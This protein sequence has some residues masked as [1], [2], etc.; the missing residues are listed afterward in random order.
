MDREKLNKIVDQGDL[1]YACVFKIGV[2]GMHTDYMFN[3]KGETIASVIAKFAYEADKIII[4][5]ICDQFVCESL[6][7]GILSN[8]PDQE[9]CCDIVKHLLSYQMGEQDS[10][11]LLIATKEEMEELWNEEEIE[12]IRA[13]IRM[14]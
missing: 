4:T 7:G 1:G 9:L 6:Y 13:E 3:I 5:D 8:C 11:G 12:V 14:L 2:N 10:S